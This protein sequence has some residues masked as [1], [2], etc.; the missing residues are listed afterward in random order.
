MSK[1]KIYKRPV[2]STTQLNI[3]VDDSAADAFR[4]FCS[5]MH[6]TQ[7]EGLKLLLASAKQNLAKITPL[8]EHILK[9]QETISAL[10]EKEKILRKE[11]AEKYH[12][13]LKLRRDLAHVMDLQCCLPRHPYLHAR[14]YAACSQLSS[15]C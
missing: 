15:F 9:Q 13:A 4:D 8:Q 2:V 5:E 6:I 11:Y 10:M 3:R 12:A 7:N 14:G 1:E